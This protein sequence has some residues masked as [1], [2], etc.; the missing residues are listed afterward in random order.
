M[1]SWRRRASYEAEYMAIRELTVVGHI[2]SPP[3]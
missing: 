2:N 3:V 1:A